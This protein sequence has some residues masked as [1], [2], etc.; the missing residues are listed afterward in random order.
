MDTSKGRD[1]GTG[2]GLSISHRIIEE[3]GGKLTVESK[4]GEGTCFTVL[5]PALAAPL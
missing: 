4:L 5:L 1:Q 3:H 2:L